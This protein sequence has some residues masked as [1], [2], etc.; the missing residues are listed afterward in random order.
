M[1]DMKDLILLT[2]NN[3]TGHTGQSLQAEYIL[4][5]HKNLFLTSE[6]SFYTN[7]QDQMK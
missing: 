1:I 6:G 7:L 5:L 3:N 2:R 4:E